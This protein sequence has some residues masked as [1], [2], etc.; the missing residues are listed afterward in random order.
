MPLDLVRPVGETSRMTSE[1]LRLGPGARV[2][3]RPTDRSKVYLFGSGLDEFGDVTVSAASVVLSLQG[4]PFGVRADGDRLILHDD[5]REEL[6]VYAGERKGT[7]RLRELTLKLPGKRPGALKDGR[8]T[9]ADVR[10]Q[11]GVI[12][13]ELQAEVPPLV[14][15]FAC[16]VVLLRV[17]LVDLRAKDGMRWTTMPSDH[18][19]YGRYAAAAA[20]G[21]IAFGAFG[22]EAAGDGGGGGGGD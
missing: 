15:L 22:G 8:D 19:P 2:R 10:I 11:N 13:L 16:T 9:V 17:V 7:G 20:A 21:G 4:R 5:E 12:R 14:A 18:S 6:I 1:R 3:L